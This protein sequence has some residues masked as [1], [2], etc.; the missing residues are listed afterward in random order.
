MKAVSSR[1]RQVEI[2]GKACQ[3]EMLTI[4]ASIACV[5]ICRAPCNESEAAPVAVGLLNGLAAID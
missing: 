2:F 5:I 4:R 3:I 1:E